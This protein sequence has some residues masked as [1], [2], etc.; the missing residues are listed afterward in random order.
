[1]TVRNNKGKIIQFNYGDDNFDS[2]KTEN[3]SISL[4]GMSIEDIYLHYDIMGSVEIVNS[5]T[6][7][8]ATRYRKQK[9][10]LEKKTKEYIEKTIQARNDLIEK[11]FSNTDENNVKTP[12]SFQN[13][14]TNIQGQLNLSENSLVDITPL[15][16]FELIESYLKKFS[17]L[18]YSKPTELFNI[19]YNF[20][21][22]PKELITKKRFHR[23]GITMLLEAILLKYKQAIVHPGE[24]VGVIAG[25]SIGEPTT[26]LT[27]NTF[28]LSGVASKSNVTRGV[29]RIE[30]ILRLTKNP[31][32]LLLQCICVIL[33]RLTKKK[34]VSMQT[35]W[36][37]QN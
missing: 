33:K 15:E 4:V 36:N 13:T 3:Q 30:E 32:I 5:F 27:L 7:G 1:M 11:V 37:I 28:H 23:K 26:Q 29:P 34:Q 10:E 35:C 12:I 9:K 8:T 20:Y 31:K 17:K 14:I 21:L 16:A 2:T 24:M 22:T 19:L 25:Q 6:K 18:S